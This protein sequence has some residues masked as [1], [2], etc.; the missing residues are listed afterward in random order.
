MAQVE[1]AGSRMDYYRTRANAV[2]RALYSYDPDFTYAY[3]S[4]ACGAIPEADTYP[5]ALT[6]PL[7]ALSYA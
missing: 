6:T 1:A 7:P 5:A 2:L 4:A 3:D